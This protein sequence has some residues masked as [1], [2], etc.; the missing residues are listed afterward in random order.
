MTTTPSLAKRLRTLL[1]SDSVAVFM[2][3]H[4]GLSAKLAYEAGFEA[5][6]GSG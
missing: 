3:A 2:E 1:S 4:N 5:L 6:W